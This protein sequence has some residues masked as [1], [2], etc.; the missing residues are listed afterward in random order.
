MSL[1]T[2]EFN[3]G[4]PEDDKAEPSDSNHGTGVEDDVRWV[5][6]QETTETEGS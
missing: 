1:L 2:P 6:D 5:S 3:D 4:V